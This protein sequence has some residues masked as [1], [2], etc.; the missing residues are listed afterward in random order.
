MPEYDP[1]SMSTETRKSL[2]EGASDDSTFLKDMGEITAGAFKYDTVVGEIVRSVSAPDFTPEYD[3]DFDPEDFISEELIDSTPPDA[4]AELSTA[5]SQLEFDHIMQETVEEM[6][7]LQTMHSQGLTGMAAMAAVAILGD[8]TTYMGG[9]Y[10]WASKGERIAR[11]TKAGLVAAA[12]NASVEAV[13]ALGSNVKDESDVVYAAV[14]GLALG[15]AAGVVFG[16]AAVEPANLRGMTDRVDAGHAEIKANLDRELVGEVPDLEGQWKVAKALTDNPTLAP[17]APIAPKGSAGAMALET[18]PMGTRNL[19]DT[20]ADPKERSLGIS[21]AA[22]LSRSKNGNVQALSKS[23]LELPVGREGGAVSTAAIRKD[24]YIATLSEFHPEYSGAYKAW[25]KAQGVNMFKRAFSL[26]ETLRFDKQVKEHMTDL[27][28]GRTTD[29]SAHPPG[30]DV[31]IKRAAAVHKKTTDIQ[32]DLQRFAGLVEGGI[33]NLGYFTR[34]WS[35]RGILKFSERASRMRLDGREV[36]TELFKRGLTKA[37]SSLGLDTSDEVLSSIANAFTKRFHAKGAGLDVDAG[38]S[39]NADS[40]EFIMDSLKDHIEPDMLSEVEK[41]LAVKQDVQAGAGHLKQAALLDLSAKVDLPDGSSVQLLD[42]LEGTLD[43]NIAAQ[44]RRVAGSS[45]LAEKGFPTDTSFKNKINE[46]KKETL[47][48][49]KEFGYKSFDNAAKAVEKEAEL[50]EFGRK[51]LMGEAVHSDPTGHWTRIAQHLK[52]MTSVTSLGGM[53]ITQLAETHRMMA[54][55][56]IVNTLKGIPALKMMASRVRNGTAPDAMIKD[57]EASFGF[58]IGKDYDRNPW[59]LRDEWGGLTAGGGTESK[60]AAGFAYEKSMH[61]V[62]QG[63]GYASGH[64]FI[65]EGQHL[66][67]MR[68]MGKKFQSMAFKDAKWDKRMQDIGLDKKTFRKVKDNIKKYSARYGKDSLHTERWHPNVK[69]PFLEALQRANNMS[70]QKQLV[71][72]TAPWM[73]STMGELL[74]QFRTFPIVAMEKQTLRELRMHDKET[75]MVFLY[76]AAIGIPMYL[77]KLQINT[78]AMGEFQRKDYIDKYTTPEAMLSG[79]TGMLGVFSVG[80]DLTSQI[81][82]TFGIPNPFD[83][84]GMQQTVHGFDPISLVPAGSKIVSLG[85]AANDIGRLW[86]SNEE[87]TQSKHKN[88]QRLIPLGNT[89]MGRAIMNATAPDRY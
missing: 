84:R 88:L 8:P 26:A 66:I 70:I 64:R 14:G 29:F 36:T 75:A 43:R 53:G 89:S 12:S 30:V 15:G 51:Q 42:L 40:R 60:S 38:R 56:G 6:D 11:A 47:D 37:A 54:Q 46:I 58:R 52:D 34:R 9:A 25:A 23:L 33:Q 50:L 48:N 57:L 21:L 67:Q 27:Q 1:F 22:Q 3:E 85:K 2:L 59:I 68:A 69:E 49:W 19:V 65:Q 74:G 76:G 35:G 16:K 4:I 86:D 61:I 82:G 41:F 81:Q 45:A 62:K 87:W 79:V 13:L 73:H 83:S 78:A 72:E 31:A 7:Y 18:G 63:L 39:L 44:N 80:T 24:R 5:S 28:W 10:A 55:V 77:A 32:W 17:I 20:F 71:G